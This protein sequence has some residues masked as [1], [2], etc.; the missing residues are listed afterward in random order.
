MDPQLQKA[1]AERITNGHPQASIVNELQSA[2]YEPAEAEQIYQTVYASQVTSVQPTPT[3]AASQPEPAAP[4]PPTQPQTAEAAPAPSSAPV[5]AS[6]TAPAPTGAT[7]VA[8]SLSH[9]TGLWI[10]GAIVAAVLAAG[11]IAAYTLDMR[12]VFSSLPFISIAPYNE[13]TLLPG[14]ATENPDTMTIETDFGLYLED[15]NPD[16]VGHEEVDELFA[17]LT[18]MGGFM[19][20]SFPEEA[21]IVA[22]SQFDFDFRSTPISLDGSSELAIDFDIFNIESAGSLRIADSVAYGRIDKLPVM[23]QGE[24]DG[25]PMNEWII[26]D[27]ENLLEQELASVVQNDFWSTIA[28]G[29]TGSLLALFNDQIQMAWRDLPS[30]SGP[31]SPFAASTNMTASAIESFDWLPEQLR[32]DEED[33]EEVQRVVDAVQ[34]TWQSYPLIAFRTDPYRERVAGESVYVYEVKLAVDNVHPFFAELIATLPDDLVAEQDM[35]TLLEDVPEQEEMELLNELFSVR[36]DLR[37]NGTLH[38]ALV[39]G[40]LAGQGEEFTQQLRLH[41]EVIYT[42]EGEDF[43]ITVPADVHEK[44]LEELMV[45]QMFGSGIPAL[46]APGALPNGSEEDAP[47]SQGSFGDTGTGSANDLPGAG[48]YVVATVN[49]I[50]LTRS[51]FERIH[52]QAVQSARQQG[53]DLNDP[54]TEQ[55]VNDQAMDTLVNTELISQ[56]AVAAGGTVTAAE[57]E[58]RFAEVVDSLGSVE[59][60][61]ESLE[62]LGLT[63]ESLRSDIEQELLIQEYLEE[64]ISVDHSPSEAEVQ[65]YYEQQGGAAQ[66]PPLDQV[67]DQVRQQLI[68][69]EEQVTIE[70][71][72]E[73]L[74]LEADIETMI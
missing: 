32:P 4:T 67:R 53:M 57:V 52:Q 60:V 38:R 30:N 9:H 51:D 1:V 48:D 25:I 16:V 15:R 50:E 54:N 58:A 21:S 70:E 44:T 36:L 17:F 47:R 18:I 69:N 3:A 41:A 61:T 49:G 73:E 19:G 56:A 59:A 10:V 28:D 5:G 20:I 46:Q 39:E 62:Q 8:T 72:L 71:L 27:D 29:F 43:N 6:Q 2:G 74:R 23:M 45:D 65:A 68:E 35:E 12:Q 11:A 40:L 55:Q 34:Q 31:P 13:V 24:L 33:A 22:A 26:L 64:V 37:P 66:L 42:N 14:I 7:A 63:E